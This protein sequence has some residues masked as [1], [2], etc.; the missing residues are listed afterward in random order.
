MGDDV[1][2]TL[3]DRQLLSNL[4]ECIGPSVEPGAHSIIINPVYIALFVGIAGLFLLFNV[5]GRRCVL[6]LSHRTRRRR[7][8]RLLW[9]LCHGLDG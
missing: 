5:I 8:L 9:L 7:W 4:S 6:S 1:N 2:L 3:C